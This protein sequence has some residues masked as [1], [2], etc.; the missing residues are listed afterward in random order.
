MD[1]CLAKM[2][3]GFGMVGSRWADKRLGTIGQVGGT[4]DGDVVCVGKGIR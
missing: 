1:H 2:E 3:G 4:V